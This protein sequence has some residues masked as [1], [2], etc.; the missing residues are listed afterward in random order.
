MITLRMLRIHY[1]I[2]SHTCVQRGRIAHRYVTCRA[3]RSRAC[4]PGDGGGGRGTAN[5]YVP[6]TSRP[7][8]AERGGGGA[9][10]EREG[11]GEGKANVEIRAKPAAAA[12]SARRAGRLRT[13]AKKRAAAAAAAA[14]CLS[15]TRVSL[16]F[17][18][19]R[20][21]PRARASRSVIRM[22]SSPAIR[23]AVSREGW[24]PDLNREIFTAKLA[25][26]RVVVLDEP[27]CEL[28]CKVERRNA[29]IMAKFAL[30]LSNGKEVRSRSLL[31]VLMQGWLFLFIN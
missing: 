12:K 2:Y 30:T 21:H 25:R 10:W 16:I 5:A 27:G 6:L 8:P 11:R 22:C 1:I 3:P 19:F 23:K 18:V 31:S 28:G 17:G 7:R 20:E 13:R 29:W 14:A 24:I 26:A 4:L 15:A 9:A